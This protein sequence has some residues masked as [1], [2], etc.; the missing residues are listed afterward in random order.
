LFIKTQIGYK[1]INPTVI[2]SLT[3]REKLVKFLF[4][5]PYTQVIVLKSESL[6]LLKPSGPAQACNGI[7]LPFT[8]TQII[9]LKPGSG[10]EFVSQILYCTVHKNAVTVFTTSIHRAKRVYPVA[11]V[12]SEV[13]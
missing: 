4:E 2:I 6:N 1:N 8:Y 11:E 3:K 9:I 5:F 12:A 10:K 13:P 7:A